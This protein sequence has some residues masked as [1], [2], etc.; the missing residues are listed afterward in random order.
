MDTR[1]R[2]VQS[3]IEKY[4]LVEDTLN[5]LKVIPKMTYQQICD[6]INVIGEVPSEDSITVDNL[7]H[8]VRSVPDVRREVMLANRQH[9]RKIVFESAEFD[10]LGHLKDMAARTAFMIDSMEEMSLQEGKLPKPQDYK[11][12]SSELRE[13][14]KQ[15]EGIHK[16]IY[17]MEVV[18]EFLGEVVNTLKE[19]SPEALSAFIAKMKGKR[20]NSHIVSELLQGGIGK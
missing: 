20:E 1:K 16:E 6:E 12:L 18:R 7:T 8:F 13:T 19:V 15:I 2:G 11:A 9:M 14:L 4:G 10:M 17:Q 5:L 3:K